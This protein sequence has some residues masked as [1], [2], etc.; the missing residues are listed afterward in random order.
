MTKLL[1]NPALVEQ[2]LDD[3]KIQWDSVHHQAEEKN[4]RLLEAMKVGHS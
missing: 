4:K 1:D 2:Q 3:L